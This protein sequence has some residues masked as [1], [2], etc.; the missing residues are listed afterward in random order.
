MATLAA[1]G[2]PPAKI[3]LNGRDRRVLA[4]ATAVAVISLV[5]AIRYFHLAFPE[6]TIDF[7]IS[8]SESAPIAAAFLRNRGLNVAGYLHAAQ[9]G[10]DD[11]TKV[12][13]EREAGLEQAQRLLR[14]RVRLWRWQ[15]RWF[16]PLQIEQAY[17]D[18]T[19]SGQ[20]VAFQHSI[21]ENAPGARLNAAQARAVAEQFLTGVMHLDLGSLQF[22]ETAAKQRPNRTDYTLTWRDAQ[23]L[24]ASLSHAVASRYL[25]QAQVR[26]VVTIHG[27]R[28]DGYDEYVHIPEDWI[29]SY[30][31]L[32]DKNNMAGIVDTA[33]LVVLALAL[34]VVFVRRV[35]RGDIRWR[36]AFWIGGV[37]AVLQFLAGLNELPLALF[38]YDTTQSY[39]AFVSGR[40]FSALLAGVGTGVA[41]LL[42]VAGAEP[43]Y[44]QR[45][46]GKIAIGRYLSRRGVR[47]KTFLISVGVGLA[48]ACFFFAYQTVFYLIANHFGAWAP[49]DVP[50]DDLLNTKLPWVFVLFMGFFPAIS[51]EF[52][53][54]MFAIPLFERWFRFLW[55]AVLVA[56]F[57]WGFGHAAYPNEPWFIRGIEVGIGGVILS[58]AMIY[59]DILAT[60][61]WH[62]TV[63]ALY[64]AMLLLRSHNLYLRSSGA[65]T[66]FIAVLPLLWAV[67]AYMRTRT[68]APESDL[69]NAA[70]GSA[71]EPAAAPPAAIQEQSPAW[72]VPRA[73]WIAGIAVA[74]GL[75]AAFA[76]HVPSW[77]AHGRFDSSPADAR[78]AAA[79]FLATQ[80]FDIAGYRSA[81]ITAGADPESGAAAYYIF[82]RHGQ[83]AVVHEFEEVLPGPH[84]QVRFFRPLEITEY[85]VGV[86]RDGRTITGFQRNIPENAAGA[87]PTVEQAEGIAEQFLRLRGINVGGM[88]LKT[89]DLQKRPARTDGDFEWEAPAGSPLNVD[90]F[91]Y[92][93]HVVTQGDRAGGFNSELFV[94]QTDERAFGRRSLPQVILMVLASLLIAAVM[95][96]VIFYFIRRVRRDQIRWGRVLR[97]ALF[98]AVV[99]VLL[100]LNTL[101]AIIFNYRTDMPWTSFIVSITIG[102][103]VTAALV[104]LSYTLLFGSAEG[105]APALRG[106]SRAARRQAAAVSLLAVGWLAGGM[107]WFAVIDDRLHRWGWPQAG[108]ALP[109]DRYVPGFSEFLGAI[110]EGVAAGTVLL[111]LY[112]AVCEGWRSKMRPLVVA[113]LAL[114]PLGA[115]GTTHSAGEFWLH[116]AFGVATLAAA[117]WF[118]SR[119]AGEN[120]LAYL[121]A[122]FVVVLLSR[123]ALELEQQAAAYR[124][125][126]WVLV[127]I[128]ALWLIWLATT[129]RAT[130]AQTAA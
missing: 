65:I 51:E 99:Y 49:A 4:V 20:V 5:I 10:Y 50:Y 129:G 78:T 81:V 110:V 68:F 120:W 19:P 75:L 52:M 95:A 127:A 106:V 94:P 26:R 23:P 97:W 6:A 61:T 102:I 27:D 34:L 114:A 89:A 107:R 88:V 3:R 83:G 30:A 64:T 79:Q 41:L 74:I 58:W 31:R 32:R 60:V 33:L 72:K 71:P 101:P 92:R 73:H 90:E 36:P 124:I 66:A 126:G 76:V 113:G 15:N 111:L 109:F 118:L 104:G 69:T 44:R 45:F 98:A 117:I 25:A 67:V 53:F 48:L 116:L 57:T 21:P 12:F 14:S 29:R 18:V 84:W 122:G 93:I 112:K 103:A 63:D 85:L 2:I 35:Q 7:Q 47:T 130:D 1:G 70:V 13:L 121:S 24:T 22:I 8:R 11:E 43:L 115:I 59:F 16:R 17:V 40:V 28:V 100:D 123:G 119:L 80:G 56:S 46:R 55:P 128:A 39:G 62:Y 42:L 77:S 86:G 9:F 125:A 38:Q 87:S 37:G 108:G 91:H 96:V 54:R 82:Q 105:D